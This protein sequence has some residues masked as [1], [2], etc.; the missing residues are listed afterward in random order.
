MPPQVLLSRALRTPPLP[1]TPPSD[2]PSPT[3]P[4][5]PASHPSPPHTDWWTAQVGV[6]PQVLLSRALRTPPLPPTP[7]PDSPS[8]AA[9]FLPS[10][11]S[12][13]DGAAA[14][15]ALLGME[16]GDAV[17]AAKA[18]AG[19]GSPHALVQV[20]AADAG[21]GICCEVQGRVRAWV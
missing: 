5:S 21:S 4:P 12:L 2:S 8:P 16:G 9:L 15:A 6:P 18:L 7:P 3:L 20:G 11:P 14:M 10:L 19:A 13:G 1:P 17:A